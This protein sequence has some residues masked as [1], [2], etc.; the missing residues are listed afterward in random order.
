MCVASFSGMVATAPRQVPASRARSPPPR[1]L[2]CV[3]PCT[4]RAG[5]QAG[6][7]AYVPGSGTRRTAPRMPFLRPLRSLHGGHGSSP[8]S[9]RAHLH[10]GPPFVT[11]TQPAPTAPGGVLRHSSHVWLS[12][13]SWTVARQAAPS[14]GFS[15]P[16]YW[17]GSPRPPPGDRPD[18]GWNP[19]LPLCRWTPYRLSQ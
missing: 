19:G 7:E 8:P 6:G 11:A 13:S 4:C 18:P 1:A 15:R 3:A 5:R 10:V 14:M 9:A 17:S 16:E 2:P 12:A